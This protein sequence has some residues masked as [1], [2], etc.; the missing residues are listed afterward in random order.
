MAPE[1]R[2][3]DDGEDDDRCGEGLDEREPEDGGNDDACGKEGHG[4]ARD[5]FYA[6][7]PPDDLGRVPWYVDHVSIGAHGFA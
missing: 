6:V 7:V 5:P 1:D 3:P 2:R 4:A